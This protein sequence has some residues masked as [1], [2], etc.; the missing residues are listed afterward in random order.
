MVINYG[1]K[2]WMC[3]DDGLHGDARNRPIDCSSG[4]GS[5]NQGR[6]YKG[7]E[8]K[9]SPRFTTA[10]RT[11]SACFSPN[12]A[13]Q[14]ARGNAPGKSP[15]P[16]SSRGPVR[17]APRSRRNPQGYGRNAAALSGAQK[18]NHVD[19]TGRCPPPPPPPGGGSP[20]TPR[21]G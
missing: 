13:S 7:I 11:T 16:H 15:C 5:A 8:A 17:A 2:M 21:W 14:E 1:K 19:F 6:V 3:K 12:G 10:L 4:A 18:S 9:H 20:G